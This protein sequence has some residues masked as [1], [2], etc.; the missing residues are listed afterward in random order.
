MIY[1]YFVRSGQMNKV[2][3]CLVVTS[4]GQQRAAL[5]Q[6]YYLIF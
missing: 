5:D 2:V 3:Y 6:I 1:F 4:R